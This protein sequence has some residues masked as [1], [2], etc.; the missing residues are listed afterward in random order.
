MAEKRYL[1]SAGIMVP[2]VRL[3]K[4]KVEEVVIHLPNVEI[5]KEKSPVRPVTVK[6]L[7]ALCKEKGIP[8]KG[9]ASRVALLDALYSHLEIDL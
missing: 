9:N 8:F 3:E 7:K 6:E 5:P 4:K 2:I 1:N